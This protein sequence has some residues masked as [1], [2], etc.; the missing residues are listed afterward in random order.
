MQRLLRVYDSPAV[1][2]SSLQV[3]AAPQRGRVIWKQSCSW[4]VRLE[5]VSF[6]QEVSLTRF[7][8]LVPG[9]AESHLSPPALLSVPLL[10]LL[11]ATRLCIDVNAFPSDMRSS[12]V[13][14]F[15]D[16]TLI[17]KNLF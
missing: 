12:L 5:Y 9:V 1:L 2:R 3:R 6:S 7:S 15:C 4:E 13:R 8:L 16:L 10:V 11:V 14:T 17:Q